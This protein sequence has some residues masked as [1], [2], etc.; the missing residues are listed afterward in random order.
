MVDV[1]CYSKHWRARI[2]STDLSTLSS[3]AQVVIDKTAGIG[4]LVPICFTESRD[5][6]I[7]LA[8]P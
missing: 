4:M 1:L 2:D 8:C 5:E 6:C 7:I 3:C